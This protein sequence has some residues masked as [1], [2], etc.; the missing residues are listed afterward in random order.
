MFFFGFF[1]SLQVTFLSGSIR[2][3]RRP[4]LIPFLPS[5][6]M[7]CPSPTALASQS[8]SRYII[9]IIMLVFHG[10]FSTSST[11]FEHFSGT[12]YVR[13]ACESSATA[14]FG[15]EANITNSKTMTDIKY[16]IFL[17]GVTLKCDYCFCG[18]LIHHSP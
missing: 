6:N 16:L 17:K 9:R 4:Q 11:H 3:C 8:D 10:Y 2:T 5:L 14:K 18:R 12:R 15:T 7:R 1:I 13:G